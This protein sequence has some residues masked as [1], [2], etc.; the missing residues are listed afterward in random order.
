QYSRQFSQPV[1]QIASMTNML[2]S[3][4]ASAERV[5]ELLDADEQEAETDSA[6]LP[7]PLAGRVTFEGVSFRYEADRPLIENLSLRVEPDQ[8]WAMVGPP[9]AGKPTLLSLL[10]RLYEL[11]AGRITLDGTDIR[12]LS[13]A[14]LRSSTGMVLQDTWLFNGS[15]FDNIPYGRPDASRQ[16]V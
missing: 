5:F 8:Q 3:A 9:G 11:D 2:Q 14:E 16:E 10:L 1:T 4:V 7:V 15:I 12:D 6:D 13:R